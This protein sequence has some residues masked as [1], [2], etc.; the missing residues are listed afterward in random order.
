[1][2]ATKICYTCKNELPATAEYFYKCSKAKDELDYSCKQCCKNK[3]KE[4]MLNQEKHERRKKSSREF[5]RRNR[6]KKKELGIIPE[7]KPDYQKTLETGFKH[8]PVCNRDLPA[9]NDFYYRS[10]SRKDGLCWCC[11]NCFKEKHEKLSEEQKLAEQK[12]KK[13]WYIRTLPQTLPKKI[14]YRKEHKEQHKHN[15]LIRR[16]LKRKLICTLTPEQWEECLQFFDYKDAYTGLL[17]TIVSQD[18]VI[19]LT[20]GGPTTR[21]NII[22]C[23]LGVNCSKGKRDME[24]WYRRQPFF[25]ELRL[26]R[27]KKWMGM[28]PNEH[29]LQLSMF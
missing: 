1:M 25:S 20:R 14:K 2:E 12:R 11:I 26:K 23:E 8:C 7:Y 6:K 21:Q 22:P 24:T 28:K 3:N 5:A 18:H 27:I 13:E 17:M 19:P 4:R 16:T 10:A 29:N 15:D 9:T